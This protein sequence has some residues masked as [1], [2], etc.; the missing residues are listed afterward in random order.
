MQVMAPSS[1]SL[2][3]GTQGEGRLPAVGEIADEIIVQLKRTNELKGERVL[4]TAGGTIEP[5]DAV[6]LLTNRSSG[7]M[8]I[9]I[10]EQYF[11]QGADVILLRST[12]SVPPRYPVKEHLFDTADD[13]EKL[14]KKCIS[15]ADICFH[16]AAVSDFF[17][18]GSR[19]K[20]SSQ[21]SHNLIL[22]PRH[23]IINS[24]KNINP[25]IFLVAFKAEAG[26][27][28]TQLIKVAKG[29]LKEAHAD[30]VVANHIDRPNQG[31]GTDTNEVFI[32]AKQ[33]AA[34]HIPLNSK[35]I[36]AQKILDM[37]SLQGAKRRGNLARMR[38]HKVRDSSTS[39]GM[40][41]L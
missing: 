41:G 38:A 27:T 39:L 5:I 23:K 33:G 19:G 35:Q 22:Q 37:M 6:R 18:E 7:K 25:N 21:K 20:L 14:V 29:K 15:Q 34:I 8:G 31:F 16:V 4:V 26:L 1:G 40:T 32:V 28:D 24:I 12:T 30:A 10:A 11:L 36:I 3:C 9:A 2:A 17:V 13:L